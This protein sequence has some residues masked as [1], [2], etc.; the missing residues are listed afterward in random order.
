MRAAAPFPVVSLHHQL[1]EQ[2]AELLESPPKQRV[3]ALTATYSAQVGAIG[4]NQ[5]CEQGKSGELEDLF[6]ATT[7]IASYH[8]STE[9]VR[10]LRC[11]HSALDERGAAGNYHHL[12]LY[13]LL[14]AVRE[15]EEANRLR[16]R[17]DEIPPELPLLPQPSDHGLQAMRLE[18]SGSIQYVDLTRQSTAAGQIIALVHPGCSYSRRALESISSGAEYKWMHPHLQLVVPR[19]T[20]WPDGAMR[21]WNIAHPQL[22]MYAEAM[23]DEWSALEAYEIPVFHLIINGEVVATEIGWKGDGNDMRSIRRLLGQINA[24]AGASE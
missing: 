11:L 22:P 17:L 12:K 7:L 14:V 15:F 13:G 3:D 1:A 9:W 24:A 4:P 23:A 5:S 10:R 19:D 21:R 16:S 18:E 20:Q 6:W 2:E 8:R